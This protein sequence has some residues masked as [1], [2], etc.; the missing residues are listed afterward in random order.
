MRVTHEVRYDASPDDVYAML[1]DPAFREQAAGAQGATKV[2]VTVEGASV[3]IDMVSPNTDIPA[4]ARKVVGVS[5]HAI[6]EEEWDGHAADFTITTP[7]MPASI[8][9]RRELVADGDGCLDTF[10]GES[11]VRIP[12]IGG[13]L[14]KLF[15]DK[16][17][18]GWDAEH[19]AGLS[20]LE[21]ER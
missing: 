7:M 20:W 18:A 12:M 3:R 17:A 10:E 6:Q 15:A 11:K 16:L 2:D 1:T 21:G 5:V 4:F 13:K 8:H 9:G 19:G 14:E